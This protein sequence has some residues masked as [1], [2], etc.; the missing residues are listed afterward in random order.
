MDHDLHLLDDLSSTCE[1]ISILNLAQA[2]TRKDEDRSSDKS[3]TLVPANHLLGVC[4][5]TM[6]FRFNWNL[7]SFGVA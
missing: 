4:L 6:E 2:A 3:S 1:G 7:L 5:A